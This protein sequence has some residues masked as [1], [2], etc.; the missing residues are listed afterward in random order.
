MSV[1]LKPTETGPGEFTWLTA[2]AAVC[3]ATPLV[4]VPRSEGAGQRMFFSR[5]RSRYITWPVSGCSLPSIL[6]LFRYTV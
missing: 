2:G 6:S 1:R 4:A 3:T 5:R